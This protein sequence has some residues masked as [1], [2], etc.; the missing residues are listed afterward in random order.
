MTRYVLCRPDAGLNDILCQIERCC[1]Y[2]AMTDRTVVV[3]T[4]CGNAHH[5][6]DAFGHY[7]SSMDARL[8]LDPGDLLER[9]RLHSVFPECVS[10]R[11]SSYEADWSAERGCYCEARTGQPLTFD[12]GRGY[13]QDLLLHHQAGGG[14]LAFFALSRL[15]VRPGIADELERRIRMIGSAYHAV[16]VRHTDYRTDYEAALPRLRATLPA[17][18]PL[19]VATDNRAVVDAFRDALGHER[20][21]SF[22][23]L[24]DEVGV[25]THRPGQSG[26]EARQQNTDALLDLLML[27]S[28]RRLHVLPVTN[29]RFGRYSGFSVLAHNLWSSKV[30]L[31]HLLGRGTLDL[32]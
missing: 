10:G 11:L 31:R 24:P 18:S 28:A 25:P 3:D 22:A 6:K 30:M 14:D 32:R 19:F 12:F 27:A 2:A 17:A 7:F 21:F 16:H 29:N 4:G 20:V 8:V 5:F 9:L 23:R 15:R 13:P 1:R 26:A